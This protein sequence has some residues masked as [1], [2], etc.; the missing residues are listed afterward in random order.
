MTFVAY[1]DE[2]GEEG[3]GKLRTFPEKGNS[4][5][6]VLG[7]ALS[8]G[9]NSA[10]TIKQRYQLFR[11]THSK[12]EK[13][14]FHFVD[15]K[16]DERVGFIHHMAEAPYIC[17]SVAV[18]KPS[19]NQT[20]IFSKTY[21]LY[22]YAARLLLERITWYCRDNQPKDST[23]KSTV[24]LIF[25]ERRGLKEENIREYLEILKSKEIE[26]D[27]YAELKHHSIEWDYIDPKFMEVKPSETYIGLQ[28]ADAVASSV[29]R[30]LELSRFGFTEP[31]YLKR[32][33][34]ILY[35]PTGTYFSY[36]VKIFPK[37][38][39]EMQAETRYRWA[40]DFE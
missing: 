9:K 3:F 15:A 23:K 27:P 22:F 1:F 25:S 14:S 8:Y 18:H 28:M 4:E 21:F 32:L 35:K 33:R 11:E 29:G 40:K 34:P 12:Q 17:M 30:A 24:G 7:A 31:R 38:T 16:H 6:F 36:G 5:W 39:P 37:F 26:K 20:D 2:C 19:I 10:E 13:W